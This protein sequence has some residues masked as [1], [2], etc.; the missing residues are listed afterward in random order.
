MAATGAVSAFRDV[1]RITRAASSSF[2][3]A[4]RLMPRPKRQA[5]FAL[6]AF[7]RRVDDIADD[8]LSLPGEKRERLQRW[9]RRID[10]LYDKGQ[11]EESITRALAAA[12][13]VFDLRREDFLAIIDG[14]EMDADGPIVAPDMATLDLYCDRV[15]SAVG[16]LSVRIFGERGDLG[17]EVAHHQGRALQLANILRDV[18]EDAALGRLYLPRELLDK[19]GIDWRDPQAVMNQPGFAPLWRELA[20]K[21]A[22]HFVRTHALIERCEAD[23][24]AARIMLKVYEKEFR[25]LCALSDE[26]LANPCRPNR[27]VPRWEKMLIALS[28]WAGIA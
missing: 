18:P 5:M 7:C 9:R 6:Y 24:R 17:R 11:G 8:P 22:A 13:P 26:E 12:I 14:M 16:R 20:D 19:H 28:V 10:I 3:W 25:R 15:A 21:A 27:L 4:M 2:Y 23:M 1:A